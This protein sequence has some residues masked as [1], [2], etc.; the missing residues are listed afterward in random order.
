VSVLLRNL[1]HFGELL[2][3]LDLDV[4][5][6][7]MLDVAAALDHVEIGRRT[8]FYFT[9]QSLLVH[10]RK[11]LAIFDEA[12]RR[13]WR[14]LPNDWSPQ[15]LRAMGEL[16]RLGPPVGETPTIGSS[17]ARPSSSQL[18]PVER[19]V[20]LSYS[21]REV[22]RRKDFAQ[23]TE[24]EMAEA[25]SMMDALTWEADLRRTRRW[26]SAA[27]RESDLRR[28]VRR[29]IRYGGEPLVVP[30][31]TRRSVRRR[32]VLICDVSGS[33]E[34]YSR[35]LLHFAHR[36]A[37]RRGHVEAFLFATRLTRITREIAS[38][39]ADQAVTRVLKRLADWGGGTRIGDSIRTFNVDW[40]RRV[41]GHGPV[42][43]LISDGW[44]RGDPDRLAQ[45]MAR[46]ARTC[47]RLIWLNP[48]LGSA[49]YQPVTR[50]MAAAL[51]FVDDFLPVHNMVSLE[52]LAAHLNTLSGKRHSRWHRTGRTTISPSKENRSVDPPNSA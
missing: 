24:E 10:R 22:L 34:R 21:D 5:A 52:A 42:V 6:G 11:D 33:M 40:A 15:D 48:L 12:F 9:L 30:T 39:G 38:H 44:D 35:V 29:N 49:S 3:A 1:I 20:P 28:L 41:G 47:Y 13:F 45:E 8:D 31:R 16:R 37:D 19:T 25:R 50:G 23:F 26:T 14:P 17:A 36:L 51:P 32:V 7:R 2:R 18:K 46:L 27:G 43:L 4:P